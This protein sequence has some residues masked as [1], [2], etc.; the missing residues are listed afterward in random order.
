MRELPAWLAPAAITATFTLLVALEWAR[1][2]RRR[3]GG[4][5]DEVMMRIVDILY[6]LPFTF[7]VIMLVV[8]FGRNFVLMFLFPR[9]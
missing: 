4:K 7:F 1:P 3:V 6:A 2:L 8:F 5:T 9:S